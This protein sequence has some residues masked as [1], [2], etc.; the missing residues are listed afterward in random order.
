MG[1][2][3]AEERAAVRKQ[4][5]VGGRYDVRVNRESAYEML[6]QR[7]ATPAEAAAP[8]QQK[9]EAKPK[10]EE[11][12]LTDFLWGTS[13]RQGIVESM[14]KQAARTVGS[15]LGRQILRGALGGI[16]GGSKR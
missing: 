12:R 6:N 8:P 10:Q 2:I 16:L 3:T 15:Q 11:N 5:L 4:S 13:R 9:T 1:A 7:K 14:A